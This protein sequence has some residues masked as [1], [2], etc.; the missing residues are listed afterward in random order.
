MIINYLLEKKGLGCLYNCADG[1]TPDLSTLESCEERWSKE[2]TSY[3]WDSSTTY[4]P[5][6]VVKYTNDQDEETI[7]V[8][9]TMEQGIPG[10]APIVNGISGL[11]LSP[12]TV[13]GSKYWKK[14]QEPPTF[15]DT[16]NYI[17]IF[18]NFVLQYCQ[19]CNIDPYL[20]LDDPSANLGDDDFTVGGG[21]ITIDGQTFN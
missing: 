19:N 18:T 14:C 21:T 5:G 20:K 17:D 16:T 1:T 12:I 8:L 7:Y 10:I 15:A 4:Y 13:L 2:G 3:T 9:Q 11:G 6:D